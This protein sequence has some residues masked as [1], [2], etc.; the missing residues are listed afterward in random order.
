MST[1]VWN[2]SK[3]SQRPKKLIKQIFQLRWESSFNPVAEKNPISIFVAFFH[4]KMFLIGFESN[5][6]KEFDPKFKTSKTKVDY[7]VLFSIKVAVFR[8]RNHFL[9]RGWIVALKSLI[10]SELLFFIIAIF[11]GLSTWVNTAAL[12]EG[13]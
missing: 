9:G 6:E 7:F 5:R 2:P 11:L 4:L 3:V 13:L 12:I 8:I 1:M 10:Y